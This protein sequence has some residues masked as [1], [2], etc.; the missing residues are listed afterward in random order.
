MPVQGEY[1]GMMLTIEDLDGENREFFRYCA[2]G[3]FRLQRGRQSGLLRYPPTTAC[4]WTGDRESEWVAVDGRG[5]VHAYGEVHHAIQ[6]AFK[7]KVPYL[8][9]LVDLDTQ[10]GRPSEHEALRV[11]GNLVMP[12]GQFARP[13]QLR[14]VGIGTRVRMVLVDVTEGMALPQWTIDE[15]A[16]QPENPWRYPQE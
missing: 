15:D 5:T 10:K 12:D 2:A 8:I 9:L 11:G 6:P 4:P 13:E 7:D 3:E 14:R 1:M 16:V